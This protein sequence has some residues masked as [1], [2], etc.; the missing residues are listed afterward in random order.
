MHWCE[1][2]RASHLLW[3][4][5]GCREL[6]KYAKHTL[7]VCEVSRHSLETLWFIFGAQ[8]RATENLT[9]TTCKHC[10]AGLCLWL[11]FASLAKGCWKHAQQACTSF[12]MHMHNKHALH[13]LA[14]GWDMHFPTTDTAIKRLEHTVSLKS[15]YWCGGL[16]WGLVHEGCC[17]CCHKFQVSSTGLLLSYEGQR[18]PINQDI[19]LSMLIWVQTY[20]RDGRTTHSWPQRGLVNCFNLNAEVITK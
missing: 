1:W 16:K 15:H 2:G 14:K 10:S 9:A 3:I 11:P 12:G 7:A 6:Q 17:P 13:S 19:S 5:W 18:F 4:L 8:A 20:N